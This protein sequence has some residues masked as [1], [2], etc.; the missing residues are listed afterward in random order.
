[1]LNQG[2]HLLGENDLLGNVLP[3][4]PLLSAQVLE[5]FT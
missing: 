1:M 5:N 4:L 2:A 3:I